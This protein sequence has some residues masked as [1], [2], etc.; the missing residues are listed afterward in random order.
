MI[1]VFFYHNDLAWL[2]A[3]IVYKKD[4]KYYKEDDRDLLQKTKD[5]VEYIKGNREKLH[6]IRAN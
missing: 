3:R 6:I 1:V 4:L 5:V 2:R